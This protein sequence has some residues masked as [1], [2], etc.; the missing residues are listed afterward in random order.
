A[1]RTLEARGYRVLTARGAEEALEISQ[2][3]PV[4]VLLT[5]IVMPRISGPQLVAEYLA[6][7]PT[8]IVIYMS[9]Y[10]DDAL[11]HYELDPRT[12]FLRKPFTPAVL[13]RTI[14]RAIDG[15]RAVA[16]QQPAGD[17]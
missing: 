8:P 1:R 11:S 16:D 13:A 10:A 12:V 15:A 2:A 6:T 7:R 9:G 5:D 3:L 4:D 17:V 14:R